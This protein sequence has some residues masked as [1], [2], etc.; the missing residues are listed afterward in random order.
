MKT[1][2]RALIFTL[3]F[4]AFGVFF[5][6]G[7]RVMLGTDAETAATERFSAYL[8]DAK[9]MFIEKPDAFQLTAMNYMDRPGAELVNGNAPGGDYE[10]YVAELFG[11]YATA[12]NGRVYNV[13]VTS[14][15]VLFY[16]KYDADGTVGI[17]YEFREG[18]APAGYETM[19]LLE[20]W[21][22]FYRIDD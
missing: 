4:A 18:A 21:K 3:L 20:E 11:E 12:V 22:L 19:E 10:A 5:S 16:T 14:D 6:Y 13:A 9:A 7:A 17:I 1:T 2:I 8:T 15:G